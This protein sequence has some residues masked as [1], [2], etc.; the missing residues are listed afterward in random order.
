MV[1]SASGNIDQKTYLKKFRGDFSPSSP[2]WIRLWE[3]TQ[4]NVYYEK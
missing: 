2:L 1:V 3:V 4:T